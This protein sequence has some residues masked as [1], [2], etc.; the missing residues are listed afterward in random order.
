MRRVVVT[1]MGAVTPLGNHLEET[2]NGMAE[3]RRGIDFITKFE[4]GAYKVKVGAE[5]KNFDP[6]EHFE[7]SEIRKN[8]LFT[9]YAVSAA[10]EAI[11]DS[12]L[13]A[14]PGEENISPERLGVYVGSGI[15]GI[16]TIVTETN[17]LYG[18]GKR[19]SPFM[20]PMMIGNM[21]AGTISIRCNAQGPTLPVVTACA[22]SSHT[23]GEAFRAIKHGYA[24]AIL[25]GGA[26]AAVCPL[27]VSGF[28]S[29]MA[30]TTN[31]DPTTA[32]TPFDKRRS[33]FVIGEGAAVL[34]LEEYEHAKARGAHIYGEICGYGNTA[35]AY[36]V[37]APHPEGAGIIRAI[38]LALEEARETPELQGAHTYINAH[39]TSTPLND[40]TETMAFKTVFGE[41]ARSI[42][43]SSTKSMTGHMLG[44]AGAVEAIACLKALETDCVPPTIGYEEPDP[45]CDLSYTPNKAEHRELQTAVSTS[46]GFG[47]HNA[48]L[49]FRKAPKE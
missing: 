42:A 28:T 22:T 19:V 45:D 32:C 44:A 26:E 6:L 5:V 29:C 13:S 37:T 3:G 25:A 7:K 17:K 16:N 21:A 10:E 14:Q 48:C 20:V 27:A 35:D 8:D 31:S 43:I 30:L 47:G 38:R 36:H 11:R 41:N 23:V 1:G 24:D 4:T 40:K 18:A 49:V 34:V 2:W 15:G 39:G 46:L 33:G 9:Q 12:G